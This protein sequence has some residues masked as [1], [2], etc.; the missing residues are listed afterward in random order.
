MSSS[1]EKQSS[2][3]NNPQFGLLEGGSVASNTSGQEGVSVASNT[4]RK[5]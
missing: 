4:S 1:E 2:S 3:D 5:G